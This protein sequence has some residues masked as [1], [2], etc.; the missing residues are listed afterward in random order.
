MRTI[1]D[2]NKEEVDTTKLPWNRRM[3]RSLEKAERIVLNLFSGRDEKSWQLLDAK[4]QVLCM[5]VLL[6]AGSGLNTD[7]VFRY[8]L[9]LA[10]QGKLCAVIRGPP[11][12]TTSPCRYR[13]PGPRPVRSKTE[14][15]GMATLTNKEAEQV[16]SDVSLWFRM[17]LVYILVEQHKPQQWKK[18]LF[19]WEQPCDPAE[20]REDGTEYFSVWQ[21]EEWKTFQKRFQL[22]MTTFDP[23][24]IGHS[25]RK[26]TTIGHHAPH[27]HE[28]HG[29]SGNGN[30]NETI[31]KWSAEPDPEKRLGLTGQ[32]AA[33]AP[34]F[35][36]ALVA[37]LQRWLRSLP[38]SGEADVDGIVVIACKH[39]P[40]RNLIPDWCTRRH[41]L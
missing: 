24:A 11:C 9:D 1:P 17:Q 40:V 39:K 41:V 30:G 34:G 32:R 21:T 38:T 2:L 5:D 3:R 25:K 15:Y 31:D 35:K 8:L 7:N 14:A 16:I 37:A 33:W 12:R 19:A 6:H 22:Q 4:T 36:A 27:L 10:I 23:D 29:M 20:Y 28:L 13:Q 18:V 26:P